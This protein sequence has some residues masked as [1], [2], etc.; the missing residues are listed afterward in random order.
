[1]FTNFQSLESPEEAC[2]SDIHNKKMP[3]SNKKK[4]PWKPPPKDPP[5][6]AQLHKNDP[7]HLLQLSATTASLLFEREKTK[8]ISRAIQS[9]KNHGINMIPGTSNPGLGDCA[10]EAIIHNNNDRQ[11]F[12]DKFVMPIS[13]YRNIW[14][15]DMA[16]RTVDNPTWNIYSRQEWLEG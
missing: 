13:Y 6:L 8:M 9:G 15:T 11:C 10:F 2:N 16:N 12:R 4:A 14:T 3:R 5:S 7:Q 1:M